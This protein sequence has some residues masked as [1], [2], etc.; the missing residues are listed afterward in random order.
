MDRNAAVAAMTLAD[1]ATERG[2]HEIHRLWPHMQSRAGELGLHVPEA[3]SMAFQSP[4]MDRKRVL[5]GEQP[6]PEAA[7]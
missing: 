1:I 6:D 7:D 2:L 4:R 5:A 3:S